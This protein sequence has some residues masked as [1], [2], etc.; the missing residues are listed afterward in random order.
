MADA[1]LTY[2]PLPVSSATGMGDE[3]DAFDR[4]GPPTTWK[5]RKN[6]GWER[7]GAPIVATA[8]RTGSAPRPGTRGMLLRPEL[9]R[10]FL[11]DDARSINS[12]FKETDGAH[13]EGGTTCSNQAEE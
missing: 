13:A 9:Y 10:G 7:G 11:L 12:V 6:L 2:P 3:Y 4:N 5:T 8:S 1:P